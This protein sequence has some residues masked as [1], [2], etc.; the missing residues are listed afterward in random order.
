LLG[1]DRL[2]VGRCAQQDNAIY[3]ILAQRLSGCVLCA[4][5]LYHP[6]PGE[7][8]ELDSP[9]LRRQEHGLR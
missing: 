9:H 4:Y 5:Y 3:P 7:I 8:G 6:V 2:E 1:A